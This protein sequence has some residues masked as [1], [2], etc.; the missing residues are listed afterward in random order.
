MKDLFMGT[1]IGHSIM[2]IAFVVASGLFLGKFKFKGISIGATWIL[3]IGILLSHFGLRVDAKLL[4][5][6]KDFGLILFV[7]AIGLQVGTVFS[8]PLKKEA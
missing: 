5:F 6:V 8:I 3:F 1:G 2:L 4:A 7:F